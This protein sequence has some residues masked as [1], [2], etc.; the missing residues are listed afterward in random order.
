MGRGTSALRTQMMVV[1][2][3]EVTVSRRRIKHCY[4]R[5][6]PPQGRVEVSAP[7]GMSAAQIQEIVAARSAWIATV[8]QRQRLRAATPP[9]QPE[10]SDGATWRLWGVDY[11][12]LLQPQPRTSRTQ[13]HTEGPWLVITHAPGSS[14]ADLLRAVQRWEQRH[15]HEV[16]SSLLRHWQQ[17]VGREVSHL[18]V[19]SMRTRWG[20]CTPSTARVRLNAELIRYPQHLLEYV[21]VH[22]LTHLHESGHGPAFTRRM[23]AYLPDWRARRTSSTV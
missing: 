1:R 7:L 20:S 5:V 6:R 9:A 12:V 23:D 3:I 21:L 11:R 17:V 22:E 10:L 15:L 13:V 14:P 4:V 8:Q 16:A 2:G 19:R 18:S